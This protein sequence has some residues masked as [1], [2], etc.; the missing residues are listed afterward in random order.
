MYMRG[1][2][3]R[4]F[5]LSFS[6]LCDGGDLGVPV[7]KHSGDATVATL[8]GKTSVTSGSIL[9]RENVFKCFAES[10]MQEARFMVNILHKI[11]ETCVLLPTHLRL[12]SSLP[13]RDLTKIS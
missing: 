2:R 7:L 4:G 11:L 8:A 13:L 5:T 9:P 1:L 12:L 3:D 6:P 10:K